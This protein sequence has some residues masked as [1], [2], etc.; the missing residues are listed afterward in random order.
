MADDGRLDVD[1]HLNTDPAQRELES[2]LGRLSGISRFADIRPG[3][4]SEFAGMISRLP[5][6]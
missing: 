1:M 2:M 5:S 3:A 4:L 6:A